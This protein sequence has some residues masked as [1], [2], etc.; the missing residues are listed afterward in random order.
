MDFSFLRFINL[1]SFII[2]TKRSEK[3]NNPISPLLNIHL[4]LNSITV[5]KEANQ[6]LFF[7]YSGEISRQFI[8]TDTNNRKNEEIKKGR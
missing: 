6:V 4:Q 1:F 5:S 3:M 8:L 2:S 7:K